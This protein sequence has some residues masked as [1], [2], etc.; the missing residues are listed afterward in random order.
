M[1]TRQ[2]PMVWDV[3][4]RDGFYYVKKEY[5]EDKNGSMASYYLK[6]YEWYTAEARKFMNIPKGLEYPIWLSMSEDMMLQPVENTLLL[7]VDI[8]DDKYIVCNMNN[9]GYRVNY[10]YVPLD[11]EDEVRHAGELKRYGLSSDD[12][13]MLTG[14]GNFYP[15]LRRKIKDSWGRVLSVP[16]QKEQDAAVTA[17]ELRREWVKEVRTFENG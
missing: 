13:L 3:L 17:W 5:I 8:P 4:Q 14:K 10:W 9:W 7:R 1:W 6:L 12:D 15:M 11:A 16:P 2:V